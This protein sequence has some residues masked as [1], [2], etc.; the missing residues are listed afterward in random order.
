MI[1]I[2]RGSVELTPKKKQLKKLLSSQSKTVKMDTGEE[3]EQL[4]CP[5]CN[6]P[7]PDKLVHFHNDKLICSNCYYIYNL[8]L[9]A[10]S[11]PGFIIHCPELKQ[12]QVTA[13]A[14]AIHASEGFDDV[15]EVL[16]EINSVFLSCRDNFERRY[17]E[18]TSLSS[19]MCQF[20]YSLSD[21]KYGERAKILKDARLFPSKEY[22]Q[23]MLGF[24]KGNY[25]KSYTPD[26]WVGLLQAVN[27]E[28]QNNKE[29]N[30]K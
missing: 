9:L 8:D 20:L 15:D 7:M 2:S 12:S 3:L 30:D 23:P 10:V 27:K 29:E 17:G 1:G 26:K 25:L 21:E 18:D 5:I 13:F 6:L 14:M 28:F 24:L 11:N 19:I 16:E 22:V 4:F